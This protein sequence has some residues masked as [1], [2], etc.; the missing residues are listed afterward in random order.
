LPTSSLIS[1]W[2]P[3]LAA[4]LWTLI[5]ATESSDMFSAS[6]T[7]RY[8]YPLLTWLFGPLDPVRYEFWHGLARKSG[9]VIGYGILCFLYFRAWRSTLPQAWP[10]WSIK[11][12]ILAWLFT[13]LVASLDEWHQSY[14]PSRTGTWHDVLL[15][16]TAALFSLILIRFWIARRTRNRTL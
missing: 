1:A 16:S 12:G 6:H 3:W 9:H 11:W 4:I 14:I 5:I 8:L 13:A 15:D 2:K 10:R 7:G